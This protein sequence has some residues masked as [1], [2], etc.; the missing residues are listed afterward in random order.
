MSRKVLLYGA[1]GFSGEIIARAAAARWAGRGDLELVLAGRSGERLAAL[2]REL[3]VGVC[4]FALDDARAVDAALGRWGVH[5]VLNAAGPFATTGRLLAQG[6]LRQGCHYVDV[7][8]EADVY[9]QLDDL[10]YTAEQRRVTLVCGA[11]HSAATS[12][13]MLRR[14][15]EGLAA[16]RVGEVGNV[17]IVF[18]HILH[19]SR[20]S[21][22]TA[23]RMIRDQAMFVRA[24]GEGKAAKLGLSYDA[25]GRREVS[26]D[27]GDAHLRT[28]QQRA[29]N[30]RRIAMA[31]N[32]IDL[33]TARLRL[34]TT[35][36]TLQVG[37]IDAFMEMPE[38]AR[39]FVQMGALSTP[40]Y[41]FP[42]WRRLMK[43]QV[44]LLPEGPSGAERDDDRHTVLLQID[45]AVGRPLIDWR[46][47]TPN[48]YDFTAQCALGV[49][50]GL[51]RAQPGWQLPGTL[52]AWRLVPRE[53]AQQGC[54]FQPRRGERFAS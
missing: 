9:R 18:S 2:A 32:L 54:K 31:A 14:A 52:L 19:P 6:A 42:A 38:G 30:P 47:E 25:T 44:D 28:L 23:W 29:R 46:M 22:R 50:E 49:V 4:A 1:N 26:F 37:R 8:G 45:D 12:D 53:L 16:Q 17:R 33:L 24:V 11:G 39:I 35:L 5:T 21:A 40:L 3:E 36:G 27:F 10:T 48:P 15:V 7:N 43:T 13:L 34:T 51:E 41:A 20:G